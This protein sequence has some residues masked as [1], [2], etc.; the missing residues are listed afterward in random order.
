SQWAS[1]A[2]SGLRTAPAR[3]RRA[4]RRRRALRF[5]RPYD[6]LICARDRREPF[7]DE[8]LDALTAIGFRRV[9]VALRVGGDAVHAVEF[10]RLPSALAE[11]R[12]HLERLAIED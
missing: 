2:R 1:S 11:R 12:Q 10:A 3:R 7:V 8:F 6:P 4:R 9:D 5:S